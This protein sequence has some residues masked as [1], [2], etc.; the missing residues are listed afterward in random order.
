MDR[1]EITFDE[2]KLDP[3]VDWMRQ[4]CIDCP[5]RTKIL[6]EQPRRILRRNLLWAEVKRVQV[7]IS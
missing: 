4:G 2:I 5:Q 6:Q 7:Q 3:I 1:K